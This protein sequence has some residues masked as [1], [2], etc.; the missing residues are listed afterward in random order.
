MEVDGKLL[1][2]DSEWAKALLDS[3]ERNL[4]LFESGQRQKM[5]FDVSDDTPSLQDES[6][7]NDS[8]LQAVWRLTNSFVDS[9]WHGF[10]DMDGLPW[11][12]AIPYIRKTVTHLRKV[13][14]DS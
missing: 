2:K 11:S 1:P 12:E 8:L 4:R 7:I 3:L 9:G 14:G 10:D 5:R 6:T 13:T